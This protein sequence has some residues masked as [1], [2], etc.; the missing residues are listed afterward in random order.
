MPINTKS[1]LG[2]DNMS[3]VNN[4]SGMVDA[5]AKQVLK[6]AVDAVVNSFTKHSQGYG[7]GKLNKKISNKK[8]INKYSHVTF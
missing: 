8:T 2:I 3:V 4:G 6:E 5:R 7:R 1:R